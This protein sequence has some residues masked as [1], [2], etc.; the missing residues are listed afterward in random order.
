MQEIVCPAI[1]KRANKRH[2]DLYDKILPLGEYPIALQHVV[3]WFLIDIITVHH[4]QFF[5]LFENA[6]LTNNQGN[7]VKCFFKALHDMGKCLHY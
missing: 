6:Y 7:H 4:Q 2:P 5:K 1:K 3:G